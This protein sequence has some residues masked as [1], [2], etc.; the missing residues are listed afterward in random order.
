MH[1][2]RREHL[3]STKERRTSRKYRRSDA[4]R[5]D[6]IYSSTIYIDLG[7]FGASSEKTPANK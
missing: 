2:A 5:D 4:I 6:A 1:Y 7:S 3:A